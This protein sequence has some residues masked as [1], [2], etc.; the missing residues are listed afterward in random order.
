MDAS[1]QPGGTLVIQG[2]TPRQLDFNTGGPGK[3]DHL[4]DENLLRQ[5][6]GHYDTLDLR[7]YE[8]EINEGAGHRG[9]SGLLG[10]TARKPKA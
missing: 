7:T 4:Y 5:A 9:M 8:A 6:F 10:L 3:L 1:L 2:Y